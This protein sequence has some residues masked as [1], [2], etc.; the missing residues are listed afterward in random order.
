MRSVYR[1]LIAAGLLAGLIAIGCGVTGTPSSGSGKVNVMLSDPATCEAP[2]GPFSQVWVTITDVKASTNAN[3]GDNDSSFV[4]LTP[5]LSPKQINLLGIADN[6]CFLATLGATQEIQAGSYQQFRVMLA[7]NSAT[8]TGNHCTSGVNCVVMNDGSQDELQLSSEAQTGIKIPTSQ[9]SSGKFTVAAGQTKDL[10][11]DFNT[12]VSI[13]AE[14]NGKFRLKP[15]LHAGE[16]T[17]TASSINGTILDKATGT[18]INGMVTVSLEQKDSTGVDRIFMSTSTDSS[19][20]F[21]FCPLPAG[22]YDMV[23]VAETTGGMA[24]A[25]VVITG[26]SPGDTIGKVSLQG[27]T[28]ATTLSG[29]VTSAGTSAGV[30]VLVQLGFLQQI[31]TGFSVTIPLLPNTTQSGTLLSLATVAGT[32]TNPCP[33]NTDCVTYTAAMPVSAA[34]VGAWASSGPSLVQISAAAY[35]ADAIAFEASSSTTRDCSVATPAE[36][37]STAAV[38]PLA[39]TTVT[40]PALAFSSCQ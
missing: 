7:P 18:P 28:A 12:C 36:V 8:I 27:P 40:V 19:G 37:M 6:Q 33:T 31:S 16:I 29:M 22:T 13:V 35:T 5:G 11:I 25:P 3:A 21:V 17:A 15:V 9:I 20:G 10:D 2:N 38:T 34:Y 24:Y 4:D 23:I 14:G 39:S 26:V 1:L 30:P 32:T